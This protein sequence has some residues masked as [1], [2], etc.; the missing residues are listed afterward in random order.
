MNITSKT[1]LNEE[2]FKR[3]KKILLHNGIQKIV[4]PVII[5]V[6]AAIY[7]AW[8]YLFAMTSL[9]FGGAVL[10]AMSLL[11]FVIEKRKEMNYEKAEVQ[12]L[13]RKLKERGIGAETVTITTV[14]EDNKLTVSSELAEQKVYAYKQIYNAEI[15]NDVLFIS[16]SPREKLICEDVSLED[17]KEIIEKIK[18]KNKTSK[19]KK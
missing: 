13:K 5:L 19:T 18:L 1:V 16:V 8:G 9:M 14:F 12:K 17:A 10:C 11:I 15:K 4:L 2:F 7:V 3:N 6:F